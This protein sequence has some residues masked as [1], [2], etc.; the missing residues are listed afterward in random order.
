M[1]HGK[2]DRKGA[3]S[4]LGICKSTVQ[5]ETADRVGNLDWEWFLGEPKWFCVG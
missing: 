4:F 3:F 1:V 2:R 5:S